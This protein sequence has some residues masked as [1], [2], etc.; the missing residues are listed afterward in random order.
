MDF[1]DTP[2]EAAVRAEARAFL[3]AHASLRTGT[4]ADWSR[5]NLSEDDG[6]A[7]IFVKRT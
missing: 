7:A 2:E 3:E 4:D 1:E 5:G 6:A